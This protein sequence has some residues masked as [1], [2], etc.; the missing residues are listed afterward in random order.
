MVGF[1]LGPTIIR[2]ALRRMHRRGMKPFERIQDLVFASG[3]HHGVS[4]FSYCAQNSSMKGRVT[5]ELGDRTN[6]VETSFHKPL[7][8]P[9]GDF[10]TPC[11]DGDI[12]FGQAGV[13]GGHKVRYTTIVMADAFEP[14]TQNLRD[15][16][17]NEKSSALKGAKNLTVPATSPDVSGYFCRGF[18]ADHYSAVRSENGLGQIMTALDAP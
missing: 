9:N 8:G 10:E 15:E 5:C 3:S 7:N 4:T 11:G 18:L 14:G 1:S 17:V 16:F 12:A 6:Y 2:D 13:C